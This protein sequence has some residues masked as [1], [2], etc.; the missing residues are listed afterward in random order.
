MTITDY[1]LDLAL[2]GV[3]FLQVRGRRL[4][5]RSLLLPV[6]IVGYVAGKYLSGIPTSGDD[7]V[8]VVAATA[9]GVV[10]GAGAALATRMDIGPDGR[11]LAKAGVLAAILWILGVGFRFA[12]QEYATHGGGAAI[13]RFSARHALTAQGWVAAL[14]LMA[15]GEV[16]ARTLVLG[17]RAFLPR[18]GRSVR[19]GVEPSIMG[20]GD[21]SL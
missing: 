6:A 5:L 8:L 9:T 21:R 16:L 18:A 1:V 15:I 19:V 13:A 12:F 4:T 17:G 2:I 10:L 14:V 20:A 3:V 7:L 11:P